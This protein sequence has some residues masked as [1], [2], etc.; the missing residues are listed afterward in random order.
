MDVGPPDWKSFNSLQTL[1][2][3]LMEFDLPGTNLDSENI[4]PS[5]V[6]PLS[7]F[8]IDRETRQTVLS[9]QSTPFGR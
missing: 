7:L 1:H 9:L 6:I 8:F 4:N 2:I 3:D 5:S